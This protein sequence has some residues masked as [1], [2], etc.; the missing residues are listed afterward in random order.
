MKK[1]KT[2]Q[3]LRNKYTKVNSGVAGDTTFTATALMFIVELLIIKK[4]KPKQKRKPTKWNKLCAEQ[5]KLGKSTKEI[6]KLY[7]QTKQP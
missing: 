6:S 2:I 7:K 4:P 1:C 5:M 3:D